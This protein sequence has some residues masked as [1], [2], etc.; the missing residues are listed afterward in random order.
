MKKIISALRKQIELLLIGSLLI[1]LLF[2]CLGIEALAKLL[3]VIHRLIV[4]IGI[5]IV[6][7][8]EI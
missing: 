3:D 1:F 2:F 6:K 5:K 7:Y 4:K 8:L